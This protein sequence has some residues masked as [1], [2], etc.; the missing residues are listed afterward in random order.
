MSTYQS[1]PLL[2][3]EP[4][5]GQEQSEFA[6]RLSEPFARAWTL[7][8]ELLAGA[9]SLHGRLLGRLLGRVSASRAA[10]AAM[11]TMRRRA[12]PRET[13]VEGVSA[14]ALY[15]SNPGRAMRPG[16]P[17][18]TRLLEPAPGARLLASMLGAAGVLE[19][20]HRE[21]LVLSGSARCG[22]EWLLQ[23]D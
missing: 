7:P 5:P 18:R 3:V 22:E 12:L 16:K 4:A 2:T 11:H 8:A 14:Q 21:W 19:A 6:P 23:P 17:L 15:E 13:L 10:E 9:D 1:N 20:R